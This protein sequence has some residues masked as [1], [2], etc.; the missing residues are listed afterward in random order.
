MKKLLITVWL[1]SEVLF[2]FAIPKKLANQYEVTYQTVVN[3]NV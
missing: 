1:L 3:G 2:V